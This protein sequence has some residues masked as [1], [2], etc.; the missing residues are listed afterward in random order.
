MKGEPRM[1][2]L[3]RLRSRLTGPTK[4]RRLAENDAPAD[5]DGQAR[6]RATGGAANQTAQNP[7]S[8]TGTTPSETFVGRVGA[9]ESMDA[10]LSGAEAR[11][12]EST[13]GRGQGAARDE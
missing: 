7:N 6:T 9:D 3:Q 8:T 13:G 12:G 10:D 4:A 5:V 11:A 1:G 2:V